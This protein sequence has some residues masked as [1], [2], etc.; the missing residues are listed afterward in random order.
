MFLYI[1]IYLSLRGPM[2]PLEQLRKE[3]SEVTWGCLRDCPKLV[4]EVSDIC[5]Q[6]ILW[7]K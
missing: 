7:D 1:Y 4:L 2:K 5:K 3:R 6:V